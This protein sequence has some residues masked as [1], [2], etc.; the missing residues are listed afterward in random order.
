MNNNTDQSNKCPICNLSKES[1]L[2]EIEYE[3]IKDR[4]TENISDNKN[5]KWLI[6]ENT[7]CEFWTREPIR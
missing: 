2:I 4:I 1:N 7:D 3:S 5:F 6:C